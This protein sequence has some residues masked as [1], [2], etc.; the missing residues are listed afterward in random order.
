MYSFD[1]F[2]GEE[3][4]GGRMGYR[5]WTLRWLGDIRNLAAY[6]RLKEQLLPELLGQVAVP[7]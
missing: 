2:R 6:A 5:L 3:Q 4:R 1:I 7:S